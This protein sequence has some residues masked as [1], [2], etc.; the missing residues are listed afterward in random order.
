[1]CLQQ[2]DGGSSL[3]H[4]V[5]CLHKLE[6]ITGLE[7]LLAVRQ[8]DLLLVYNESFDGQHTVLISIGQ[9]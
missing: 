8:N 2:T 4:L 5:N 1:M 9:K 6:I 3:M 7:Y